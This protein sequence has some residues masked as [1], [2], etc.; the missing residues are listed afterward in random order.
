MRPPEPRRSRSPARGGSWRSRRRRRARRRASRDRHE[1][2]L[3][4]LPARLLTGDTVLVS[5]IPGGSAGELLLGHAADLQRGHGGAFATEAANLITA[6]R[7]GGAAGRRGAGARRRPC[8]RHAERREPQR[9]RRRRAGRRPHL[10]RPGDFSLRAMARASRSSLAGRAARGARWRG[11]PTLAARPPHRHDD[12]GLSRR[13]APRRPRLTHRDAARPSVD[14]YGLRVAFA[15]RPAGAR[16]R[17]RER[18]DRRLAWTAST[19][20]STARAQRSRPPARAW[21]SRPRGATPDVRAGRWRCATSS[22]KRP[23]SSAPGRPQRPRSPTPT[24]G[25]RRSPVRAGSSP[26]PRAPQ[27]SAPAIRHGHAQVYVADAARDLVTSPP[28]RR[29]ARVAGTPTAAPAARARSCRLHS[30]RTACRS[31]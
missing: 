7:R 24:R 13:T 28:R 30:R 19:S 9:W 26:S 21:R 8:R 5:R 22:P 17:P 31:G 4:C 3:R 16:A 1:R 18:D 14:Q 12:A 20:S 2:H 29:V 27:T 11:R 25:R 10:R 6:R 23:R 15:T